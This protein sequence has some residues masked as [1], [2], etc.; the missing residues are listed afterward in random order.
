MQ[1]SNGKMHKFG[2]KAQF[3][4]WCIQYVKNNVYFSSIY[5]LALEKKKSGL[6]VGIEV[7]TLSNKSM[8]H[9]I[10]SGPIPQNIIDAELI[11]KLNEHVVEE[12]LR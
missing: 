6:I 10:V 2:K 3:M 11:N 1:L 7:F 12:A 4:S 5:T 9:L 8:S